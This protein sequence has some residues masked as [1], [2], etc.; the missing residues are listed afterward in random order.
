MSTSV[1]A[2]SILILPA[3][4]LLQSEFVAAMRN[5]A[6][7]PDGPVTE[8]GEYFLTALAERRAVSTLEDGDYILVPLLSL[9]QGAVADSTVMATAP[10][11][12]LKLVGTPHA[13]MTYSVCAAFYGPVTTAPFALGDRVTLSG[14]SP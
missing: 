9:E 10:I 3:Y 7:A 14:Q 12:F 4:N 1:P 6:A 8:Q 5:M 13:V 2:S 11:M